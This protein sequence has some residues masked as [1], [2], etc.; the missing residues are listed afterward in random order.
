MT[1]VR[2]SVLSV[3]R[4]CKSKTAKGQDKSQD[5]G[6]YYSPSGPSKIGANP[7]I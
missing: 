5:D 4:I 2:G 3:D 1:S 7:D 6:Q